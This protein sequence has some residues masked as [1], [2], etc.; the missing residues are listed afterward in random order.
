MAKN[1]N[2]QLGQAKKQK[3]DEFYTRLEDIERELAHYKPHFRGKTIL[4]NCDDPRVSNFFH[5]FSHQFEA[6]GL[7]RLITTCYKNQNMDLFSQNKSER[8]IYLVYNGDKNGNRIPDPE[9]I[10]I[11]ELKGDGD[12]RSAECIELLK[13]A[14]IVVTNP[15]FSLFREYVAQLVQYDKKFLII[16]HQNAI[17]YKEIFPLIM[18]NKLWLGYG[19]KGNAAHFIANGYEDYATSGDHRAGMI[20]VSGVTWF[21]NLDIPKNHE[22]QIL[23]KPYVPEEYPRYVNYD[24]IEVSQSKDIPMNYE[25]EMG[26]PI[27]FM[28]K[29]NPDQFEIVGMSLDLAD[30][31]IVRERLGRNDGGPTFYIEKDGELVRLYDRI[32]IRRKQHQQRSAT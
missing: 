17:K 25:G 18:A 29:Y 22:E 6:L 13:Q 31:S 21:T 4:C 16:G 11:H 5:Y 9:E 30:M 32:V 24:A 15:P 28:H 8:A 3:K 10:G 27:T 14:D 20:R 19:F 1:D 7:K 12:F 23:W 2:Q 26:V